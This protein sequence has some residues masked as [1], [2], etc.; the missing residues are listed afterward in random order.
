MLNEQ[1]RRELKAE[2]ASSIRRAEFQRL[3]RS[4]FAR[5]EAVN[6]DQLLNFLTGMSRM[7]S[8]PAGPSAP[9][10]SPRFLL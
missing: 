4:S 9:I 10:P 2:A 8:Q 3:E 5:G 7:F 6:L 1:E